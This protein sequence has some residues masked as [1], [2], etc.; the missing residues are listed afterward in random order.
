MSERLDTINRRKVAVPFLLHCGCCIWAAVSL[1]L[2]KP[3][4]VSRTSDEYAYVAVVSAVAAAA[5]R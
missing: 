1:P 4:A 2:C 3:R 5:T